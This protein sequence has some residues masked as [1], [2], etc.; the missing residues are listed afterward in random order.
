MGRFHYSRARTIEPAGIVAA[1]SIQE[2]DISTIPPDASEVIQGAEPHILDYLRTFS[3]DRI[4]RCVL[5]ENLGPIPDF[6]DLSEIEGK[7]I[8]LGFHQTIEGESPDFDC[9]VMYVS[10]I[11]RNTKRMVNMRIEQ[12][13]LPEAHMSIIRVYDTYGKLFKAIQAQSVLPNVPD[14]ASDHTEAYS[15]ICE[16][17]PSGEITYQSPEQRRRE[18]DG[19][20]QHFEDQFGSPFYY[21]RHLM[22][23]NRFAQTIG[24]ENIGSGEDDGY[25][26][27]SDRFEVE[28]VPLGFDTETL[29]IPLN[30]AGVWLLVVDRGSRQTYVLLTEQADRS[31]E[32]GWS[33]HPWEIPS[34][35]IEAADISIIGTAQREVLEEVGVDLTGEKLVPLVVVIKPEDGEAH[36]SI[37]D[38]HYEN[39]LVSRATLDSGIPRSGRSEDHEGFLVSKETLGAKHSGSAGLVL[40]CTIDIDTLR[41]NSPEILDDGTIIFPPPE[42]VDPREISRLALIPIDEVFS[43]RS[44]LLNSSIHKWAMYD[45][46]HALRVKS[47][48]MIMDF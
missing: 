18:L 9:A 39:I 47:S 19:Y 20:Y 45:A 41:I 35:G 40:A 26:R 32:A 1:G 14:G 46:L 30:S 28:I 22:W 44:P 11:D 37:T 42:S 27:L 43:E 17:G 31:I 25:L 36:I 23:N 5:L 13:A 3:P 2:R 7:T 34:G 4:N 10:G 38:R 29:K 16:V 33:Q 8:E 12:E 21:L 24:H 6:L 15:T 48:Q